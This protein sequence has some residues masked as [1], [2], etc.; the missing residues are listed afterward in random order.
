MNCDGATGISQLSADILVLA[1]SSGL[2][3]NGGLLSPL[4]VTGIF[5]FLF[6]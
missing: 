1:S 6:S 5:A 3:A 2:G 4:P